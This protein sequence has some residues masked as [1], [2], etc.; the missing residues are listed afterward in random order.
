MALHLFAL[1]F[2][3]LLLKR[4]EGKEGERGP[5]WTHL[6]SIGELSPASVHPRHPMVTVERIRAP[7]VTHASMQMVSGGYITA[8]SP[9]CPVCILCVDLLL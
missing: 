9:S 6:P 2:M 5:R 8:P 1:T 4:K 7:P 3:E